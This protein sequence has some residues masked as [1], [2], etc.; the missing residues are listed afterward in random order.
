MPFNEAEGERFVDEV[1]TS[2]WTVDW[3]R[4]LLIQVNL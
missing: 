3:V 2:N 1:G 4:K